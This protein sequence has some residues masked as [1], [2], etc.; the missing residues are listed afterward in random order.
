MLCTCEEDR[1]EAK[2]AG[3]RGRRR[4]YHRRSC[5]ALKVTVNVLVDFFVC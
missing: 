1:K 2:V 4:E 3:V 5:R